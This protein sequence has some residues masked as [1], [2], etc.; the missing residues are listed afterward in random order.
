MTHFRLPH[1]NTPVLS[2]CCFKSDLTLDHSFTIIP[3][4][5]FSCLVVFSYQMIFAKHSI[6]CHLF[7]FCVYTY[8]LCLFPLLFL[9][10]A[11]SSCLDHCFPILCCGCGAGFLLQGEDSYMEQV[12]YEHKGQF[13]FRHNRLYAALDYSLFVF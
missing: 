5:D 3:V 2:F 6:T 13:A 12:T 7:L 1:K 10:M 9:L 8:F 4:G 11:S